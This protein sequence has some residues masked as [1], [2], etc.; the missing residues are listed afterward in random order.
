MSNV[1]TKEEVLAIETLSHCIQEQYYNNTWF[2][3]ERVFEINNGQQGLYEHGG[4]YVT[5]LS[6]F[7]QLYLPGVAASLVGAIRMA[8]EECNWDGYHKSD[9]PENEFYL[10]DPDTL[11]I[12]TAEYLEYRDRG[13]L[14]SHVDG[15]SIYSISVALS[16][17]S[18]YKGGYF[19]LKSTEALFKVPRRSAVVFWSEAL[20]G[21]TPIESNDVERRVL[22]A[23]LW[24]NDDPPPGH[25]RANHESFDVYKQDY[26][27][28]MNSDDSPASQEE[29]SAGDAPK[30]DKSSSLA[31]VA[32]EP[33][34]NEEL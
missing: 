1:L 21:V 11:G 23:E 29:P 10:P 16:D 19:R 33:T 20:H 27:Q 31:P 17:P 6:G 34:E 28:R 9:D 5:F 2:V 8:H 12:R 32:M 14:G 24:D 30:E 13:R 7:L 18:D 15:G 25:A 3:E 4:N 26:D 22:V